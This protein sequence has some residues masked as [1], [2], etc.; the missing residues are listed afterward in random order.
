M[1]YL[2]GGVR[3]VDDCCADACWCW[4]AFESVLLPVVEVC[5]VGSSCCWVSG[6]LCVPCGMLVGWL[7]L[8]VV[9]WLVFVLFENCI[10]DASIF[11]KNV[12]Q[13]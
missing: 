11:F 8:L 5:V 2:F 9:G 1:P 13:L 4:C 10:V 7:P 6:T 3:V 12:L